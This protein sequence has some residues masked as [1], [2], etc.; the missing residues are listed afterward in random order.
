MTHC[1]VVQPDTSSLALAVALAASGVTV[2]VVDPSRAA[3][4]EALSYRGLLGSGE[5]PIE[6]TTGIDAVE[7][8]DLVLVSGNLSD[9]TDV[10][11]RVAHLVRSEQ[12]ILLTPGGVGGALAF[13]TALQDNGSGLPIIAEL[14]GFPYLATL[15]NGILTIDVLKQGIAIGVLPSSETEAVRSRFA[16]AIPGLLPASSVLETGLKNTNVM[17]HPAVTLLN[18]ARVEHGEIFHFYREGI[19]P[20]A[21]RLIDAMDRERRQLARALGVDD[22][23]IEALM[24]RY[25]ADDGM[26]GDSIYEQLATF[27]PFAATAGPAG[28]DHRYVRDDI[29][30]GIAPMASIG[31]QIG[32]PMPLT[33]ALVDLWS[34]LLAEDLW[35]AGNTTE[36]MG[37]GE[38]TIA[39]LQRVVTDGGGSG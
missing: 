19:G 11:T 34:I 6:W 15:D 26:I 7:R 10:A 9:R 17:I 32:V 21:G 20:S 8:A 12:V 33:A 13:R 27:E 22:A 1:V 31:R 3:R 4:S 38:M 25:Y 5:A 23:P 14:P 24:T 18:A 16:E 28:F 30:F 2:T 29:P 37:I 39:Q 35:R 36:R